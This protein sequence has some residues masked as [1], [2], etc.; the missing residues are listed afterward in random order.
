MKNKYKTIKFGE[1][2]IISTFTIVPKK[3]SWMSFG[4]LIII[5]DKNYSKF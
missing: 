4:K 2:I 3:F 1:I 5:Q